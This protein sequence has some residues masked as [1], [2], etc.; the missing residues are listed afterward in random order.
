MF[1]NK[2]KYQDSL[3]SKI[4]GL[5]G[6]DKETAPALWF[7]FGCSLLSYLIVIYTE[8]NIMAA[9]APVFMIGML[10]LTIY[11][12]D[13][14]L[15]VLIAMVLLFDQFH[16][17]GFEPLTYRADYFRN[18]KEVS[19]LPSFE[20]GV[21]NII[22]VHL[23]LILFIWF[24]ILSIKKEF[25]FNRLTVWGSFS[26]LFLWLIYSFISGLKSGGEF[27]TGLWEVRALF[28]FALFY[29]IVPQIIQTKEQLQNIVWV[30]I[31]CISV[32]AF[33]GIYRFVRLGFGFGGR[34]TLTNHED[35]IFIVTLLVLLLG[36]TFYKVK[37]NQRNTLLLLIIPLAIG[38]FVAQR[39][40]AIASLIITLSATFLLL[41]SKSQFKFFKVA[42][43][44]VVVLLI[45]GAAFWNSTSPLATPVQMVKSGLTTSKEELSEEDYYSNLYREYE[46]YNLAYTVTQY[47]V[48]GTG[49]GKK[50]EK[51][52]DLANID[53]SLR[54]YIPHNQI[55]WVIVKT[56][57]LGFFLFWLFFNS[58]AFQGAYTLMR[59]QDPYLK[60]LCLMI[61]VAVIN[62]MVVSY[63]DLQL[64]YYRN[65]IYLG[66]LLGLMPA[67]WDIEI[68][69]LKKKKL[70]NSNKN[71]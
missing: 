39:R 5:I 7:I 53:F 20:L 44:L 8:G 60:A 40:A 49:F 29:I 33:Q 57:G 9:Y 43:P 64:T 48:F 4:L 42:A 51:P 65:M 19:Y 14:S 27:L 34:P 67:I 46:N 10:A 28:Y 56:G 58:F 71:N 66:C 70:L 36:M 62:Q 61:T 38:F 30:F 41:P 25:K 15:L 47:P 37:N 31:F 32:K 50:Y 22:E 6:L 3:S 63:F 35:P 17:P 2:T 52:L 18:L 23:V 55:L 26:I 1:R 59:L 68:K 69:A 45:Y 54:D 11:R 12:I 13:Y 21:V 24:I 16:I